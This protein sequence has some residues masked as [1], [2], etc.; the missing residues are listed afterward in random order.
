VTALA[1]ELILL[2]IF[3]LFVLVVLVVVICQL[4]LFRHFN[5]A[6]GPGIMFLLRSS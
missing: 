6:F 5:S 4:L 3:A 1:Q 2:E